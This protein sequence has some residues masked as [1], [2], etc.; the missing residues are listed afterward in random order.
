MSLSIESTFWLAS[1]TPERALAL[2]SVTSV[3]TFP[4]ASARAERATRANVAITTEHQGTSVESCCCSTQRARARTT[5]DPQAREPLSQWTEA[6]PTHNLLL[7]RPLVGGG[8]RGGGESATL[9][10][11][12]PARAHTHSGPQAR[13]SQSPWTEV[14]PTQPA[15][16]LPY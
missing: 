9:F 14:W 7:H 10:N 3:R 8:S 11:T 2:A 5:S 16:T 4:L 6:W 1:A 13:E 15:L 12:T